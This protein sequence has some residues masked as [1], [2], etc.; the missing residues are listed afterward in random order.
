MMSLISTAKPHVEHAVGL[1]EHQELEVVEAQR[2]AAQVIEHPA[3]G[4]RDDVGAAANPLHLPI[5][6]VAAVDGLDLDPFAEPD[7]GYLLGDLDRQLPGGSEHQALHRRPRGVD[8]L[9]HGD[10]E[11][12]GLA[13]AGAGLD[14]EV[15]AVQGAGDGFRLHFGGALVTFPGQ[16]LESGGGKTQRGEASLGNRSFHVFPLSGPPR[17][18]AN[19][20][21][22]RAWKPR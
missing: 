8:A 16:A 5:H 14:H 3:R 6:R 1:V 12:R 15:L 11:G 13:G 9:D 2:L 21:L 4:A 17:R 10:G 19:R 18:A 20:A 22:G 7:L